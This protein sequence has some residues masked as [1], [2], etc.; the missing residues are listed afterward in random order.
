MLS[1]S[2]IA[3]LTTELSTDPETLGY[4]GKSNGEL[5]DIL[6]EVRAGAQFEVT[7]NTTLSAGNVAEPIR[8][9]D[10]VDG[11]T[12]ADFAALSAAEQRL[13]GSLVSREVVNLTAAMKAHFLSLFGA[14]TDTRTNLAALSKRQ[15]SRAEVL[16]G[17]QVTL[18]DVRK[19]A[20]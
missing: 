7:R 18:E 8:S 4:T 17:E 20:A 14:G 3:E 6:N 11:T 5:V 2:Q 9:Q 12:S 13:Y 19:A 1:D 15:G 16:F 10:I